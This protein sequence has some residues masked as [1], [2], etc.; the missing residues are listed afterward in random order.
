MEEVSAASRE[1]EDKSLGTTHICITDVS[2]QMPHDL[3]GQITLDTQ[4]NPFCPS[5]SWDLH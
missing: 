4:N 2:G 5:R 3:E 1:R